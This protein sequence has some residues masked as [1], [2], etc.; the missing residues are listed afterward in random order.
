MVLSEY[1]IRVG[2][3]GVYRSL[4]MYLDLLSMYTLYILYYYISSRKPIQHKPEL[5]IM[6]YYIL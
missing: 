1:K 4:N 5:I 2:F 3:K 6:N